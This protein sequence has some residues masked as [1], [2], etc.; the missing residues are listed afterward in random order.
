MGGSLLSLVLMLAAAVL[1][2][3]LPGAAWLAWLNHKYDPLERLAEAAGISLSLTAL[4]AVVG[5]YF[6][7]YLSAT[8]FFSLYAIVFLAWITPQLLHGFQ[9]KP[10]PAAFLAVAAFLCISAWRLYQARSLVFPAW[11]DPVHHTLLVRLI[12]ETGGI[13]AT[14]QPYLPAPFYYHFGF[15]VFAAAFV[16]FSQVELPQATLVFGQIV[17][18]LTAFSVYRLGKA[19][20]GDWKRAGLAALLVGFCFQ[21]PAYYLSWGR[22]TLLAG[23]VVLP[24]AMAAAL[25]AFQ[26]PA[27][28]KLL[29][30]LSLYTAAVFLC[31]YLAAILLFFFLVFLAFL[32]GLRWLQDRK[33]STETPRSLLRGF[34]WQPWV[35]LLA[36]FL[37]VLPWVVRVWQYSSPSASIRV[38]DLTDPN[39]VS[40]LQGQ[41]DYFVYLAGPDLNYALLALGAAGLVSELIWGSRKIFI[42]WSIVL[43]FLSLPVAPRIA[44]FRFDHFEIVLFIP[45]ALFAAS[46][47]VRLAGWLRKIPIKWVNRASPM[48]FAVICLVVLVVGVVKTPDVIN[49][50]TVFTTPADGAAITW[51]TKNTPSSARFFINGTLWQG[52]THRGV[53]GG[54]WIMPATGRF[55][56]IPPAAI[57]W[58][59]QEDI[60]AQKALSERVE[61]IKTC[62]DSFWQLVHEQNLTHVYLKTGVGSL[63]AEGLTGCGGVTQIY[64]YGGVSIYRINSLK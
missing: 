51:I 13:P 28:R 61:Q 14:W 23:L 17:N 60:L 7:I 3:F 38:S 53:D 22:Y 64:T 33:H 24:L 12:L 59:F 25:E 46:L 4:L 40:A 11:V 42:I 18:G 47:L 37:V 43:A 2:I 5:F 15:H 1:V 36:G 8:A 48:S 35:A 62:D 39:V 9:F 57:G 10:S 45:G 58:S 26:T 63:Q 16:A 29:A 20:W 54:Y 21:M 27:D 32:V 52:I 56:I 6:N 49:P 34:I 31:H 41:W 55:T 19:L 44:P 30:R 50:V